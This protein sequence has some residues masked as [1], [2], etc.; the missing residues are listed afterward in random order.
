MSCVIAPVIYGMAGT[1]HR[2]GRAGLV[3]HPSLH[4]AQRWAPAA[5]C[6]PLLSPLPWQGTHT[7]C[8]WRSISSKD[9]MQT[10]LQRLPGPRSAELP[11][12][13]SLFA[14]APQL[15]PNPAA[16]GNN[17]GCFSNTG[18]E[19]QAENLELGSSKPWRPPCM[20]HWALEVQLP[21]SQPQQAAPGAGTLWWC[22]SYST[23]WMHHA[24]ELL[25]GALLRGG[26][27]LNN[28]PFA[29]VASLLHCFQ[30]PAGSGQ[31]KQVVLV[32][33]WHHPSRQSDWESNPSPGVC[34][35]QGWDLLTLLWSRKPQHGV[36]LSSSIKALLY[37]SCW[38]A[39]KR[40]G[41]ADPAKQ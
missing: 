26:N 10:Q 20:Q 2:K 15:C 38:G 37:P 12:W 35:R 21:W 22:K 32:N 29:F 31:G 25:A 14:W 39:L 4:H 6:L 1:P 19:T 7:F 28:K 9:Q 24:T 34:L 40:W 30:L 16:V 41:C 27:M 11:G 3:M 13:E 36:V 18:E 33:N 5:A 8:P 17:P 23:P